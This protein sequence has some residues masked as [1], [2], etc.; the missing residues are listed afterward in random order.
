MVSHD[1]W[2]FAKDDRKFGPM[3]LADLQH[4]IA[5]GEVEATDLVWA[6]GDADWRPAG[7]VAELFPSANAGPGAP[8]PPPPRRGSSDAP[9][10]APAEVPRRS[11]RREHVPN[12]LW[13]S[14]VITLLCCNPLAIVAIVFAAKVDGLVAAGQ[15]EQAWRASS[16]AKTWCIVAFVLSVAAGVT[17]GFVNTA[18]PLR[19][20]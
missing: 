11:G 2:Y 3:G 7:E 6:Q 15:M 18:I 19:Y 12:Y 1:V 4:R 5:T 13:Q 16:A 10:P 9:W 17:W 8:P 14:I 20:R